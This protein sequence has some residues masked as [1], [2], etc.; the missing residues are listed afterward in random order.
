MSPGLGIPSPRSRAWAV[1]S[2]ESTFLNFENLIRPPDLQLCF[3]EE[4]KLF[5]Q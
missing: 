2:F 1:P 5:L 3:P 4:S